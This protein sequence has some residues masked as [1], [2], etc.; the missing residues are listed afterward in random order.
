VD[1]SLPEAELEAVRTSVKRGRPFGSPQW[2]NRTARE[3]GLE[4]TLRPRGR[5]PKPKPPRTAAKPR[6]KS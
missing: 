5:P 4:Y 2:V 3:L 6:R 1:R